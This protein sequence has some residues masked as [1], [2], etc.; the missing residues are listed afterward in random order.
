MRF[1]MAETKLCAVSGCG[2]RATSKGWCQAHYA[3]WRRNGDPEGGRNTPDRCAI[4]GCDGPVNSRGWCNAHY[5]RWRKHGSPHGGLHLTD[6]TGP[7]GVI[8]CEAAAWI[9]GY[10][11]KHYNR[12]MRNGD[13][14]AGI[15]FHGEQASALESATQSQTDE[16]IIWPFSIADN[17]YGLTG[18][19][20]AKGAHRAVCLLA[21]GEPPTPEHEV[22]HSCNVRACINPRHVRW[23][24][25]IE[26]E[27][28]KIIH[29]TLLRGER[30]PQAKLTERD[31]LA[32]RAM[33]GRFYLRE[34]AARFGISISTAHRIWR[35][36][37]WS[38][39]KEPSAQE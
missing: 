14:L 8:G 19:A 2:K 20:I 33:E 17:G 3:R 38:W 13:P 27:A 31:V 23:A 9:R 32:I 4:E 12:L 37:V 7:C 6:N 35:R 18:S 21:H 11:R 15:A 25:H 36:E 5:I 29:D 1:D 16:C 34:A 28:D 24:T 26:N 30:N 39:L 10:C 22:A